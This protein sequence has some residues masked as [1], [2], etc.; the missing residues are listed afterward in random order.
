MGAPELKAFDDARTEI[1][2]L[3]IRS[4]ECEP[5]KLEL[6]TEVSST[7]TTLTIAGVRGRDVQ[8]AKMSNH[9]VLRRV[10][11]FMGISP[12]LIKE[13]YDDKD[14]LRAI[15]KHTLSHRDND[16][17]RFICRGNEVIDITDTQKPFVSPLTSF[18]MVAD[19]LGKNIFGISR[20]GVGY[21][22]DGF[23]AEFVTQVNNAPKKDK[24]DLSYAGIYFHSDG[25]MLVEP[26][27]YR[28]VCSNGAI[29]RSSVMRLYDSTESYMKSLGS[30]VSVEVVESQK[31]LE[32]FI[33]SA[34]IPVTD[35]VR[36][37]TAEGRR[38]GLPDHAVRGFIESVPAMGRD[39][40]MYDVVNMF[41]SAAN[42]QNSRT[43]RMKLQK[44][45]GG[46]TNDSD[47][48]NHC[49]ECGQLLYVKHHN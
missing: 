48:Y 49:V 34:E 17:V 4:F 16:Q 37:I 46:L 30:A 8:P 6:A 35:P 22:T 41:T 38:S 23:E 10:E 7:A 11:K 36:L 5:S 26:F 28:L 19:I 32:R 21:G 42:E 12:S 25:E 14:L 31:M 24:G 1:E 3:A 18:D 44:A 29:R 47:H 45:G 15:F 20:C 33:K 2:T 9:L 39:V 13:F 43:A 27:V 40:T